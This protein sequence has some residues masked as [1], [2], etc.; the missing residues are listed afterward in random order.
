M[1]DLVFPG[2]FYDAYLYAGKLFVFSVNGRLD[3]IDWDLLV[4]STS[5]R[6]SARL[7]S[8]FIDN[9]RARFKADQKKPSAG[10]NRSEYE[11]AAGDFNRARLA[12]LDAPPPFPHSGIEIYNYDLFTSGT[13]GVFVRHGLG[14]AETEH[15]LNGERS[16]RIL[17]VPSGYLDAKWATLIVAGG[18]DGLFGLPI[19]E[20][21]RSE[22]SGRL[23]VIT[24]NHC[25]Q[26]NFLYYSVYSSSNLEDS[27]ALAQ[28][29]GS[30]NRGEITR[31]FLRHISGNELLGG[32]GFSFATYDRVAQIHGGRELR[33]QRTFESEGDDEER[34][35]TTWVS[36]AT[37]ALEPNSHDRI[38]RGEVAPF[39]VVIE[40]GDTLYS[41]ADS[42]VSLDQAPVNWRTFPRALR[43]FFT[44]TLVMEDALIVRSYH[45]E[46]QHRR[47]QRSLGSKPPKSTDRDAV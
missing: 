20:Q 42:G 2:D 32:T 12:S 6:H 34:P 11:I 9:R 25:S 27:G 7:K 46:M 14:S 31:T 40:W 1:I 41:I 47:V 37:V 21:S 18:P 43:Y 17:D 38:F 24:T 13:T 44:A 28:Y 22:L 33:V 30:R 8:A 35:I 5:D 39:G 45:R 10:G 19:G 15:D 26:G 4:E 3:I 16:I 36:P 29:V 23:Q